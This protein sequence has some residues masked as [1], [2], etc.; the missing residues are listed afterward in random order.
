MQQ[1]DFQGLGTV[2]SILIDTDTT[3]TDLAD[4]VKEVAQN[5]ERRFS[6]FLVD[7]EVNAFRTAKPGTYPISEELAVL[8]E[9]GQA[10][11]LVTR[12]AYNPAI[13]AVLEQAGY[14][15][16]QGTPLVRTNDQSLA[17]WSLQGT[18]LT[19]H[20][21]LAFDLGGIGKGYLIDVL[22]GIIARAGHAHYLVDGGGDLYGTTK[23]N[24]EPWRAAVEYP[25]KP[26]LAASVVE[27]HHQGLAVSDSFRR[28]FGKHHHVM[29]AKTQMSV[30]GVIGC[31]ALAPTAWAADCMTSALFLGDTSC[32]Q[33]VRTMFSGEYIVFQED[34]KALVSPQ[35]PGEIFT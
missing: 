34:G 7:S 23:Q 33:E 1:I 15:G 28:R 9:R 21:P 12:G 22:G 18:N 14:G 4:E 2:W 10:L 35:W 6:R 26:E 17:D 32:Y 27:L 30:R 11:R 19:L 20:G 13:G 16:R 8:L 3:V 5:F 31:A 25:G 24:N 29:N